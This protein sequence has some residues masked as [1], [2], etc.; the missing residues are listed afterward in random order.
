MARSLSSLISVAVLAIGSALAGTVGLAQDKPST[1]AL[2]PVAKVE[3]VVDGDTIVV[4]LD[5]QSVRMRL[6]GVDA[7][8]SVDPRKP[9]GKLEK[10]LAEAPKARWVVADMKEDWKVIYPFQK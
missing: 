5:G 3:R 8:E 7:P 2:A 6:I 10:A 9:V 1:S 4:R